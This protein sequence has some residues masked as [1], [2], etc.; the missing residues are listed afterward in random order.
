MKR[1]THIERILFSISLETVLVIP[2]PFHPF[3]T[4][5]FRILSPMTRAKISKHSFVRLLWFV[6]LAQLPPF[7]VEFR[8]NTNLEHFYVV[9]FYNICLLWDPATG[10]CVSCYLEPTQLC[11]CFIRF[12]STSTVH[13]PVKMPAIKSFFVVT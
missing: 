2:D 12:F 9:R 11:H 8:G 4:I 5:S 3:N 10:I 1:K 6:V 7:L 13:C